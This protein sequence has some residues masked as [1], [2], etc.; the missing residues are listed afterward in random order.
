MD[1]Q[2]RIRAASARKPALYLPGPQTPIE[3]TGSSQRSVIQY[4]RQLWRAKGLILL[5]GAA[6]AILALTVSLLEE[7][8]YRST[9]SLEIEDLNENLFNTGDVFPAAR[10]SSTDSYLQTQIEVL[11]SRSLLTRVAKAMKLDERYGKPGRPGKLAQLRIW[12]GLQPQRESTPMERAVAALS[13]GLEIVEPRNGSRIVRIEYSSGDPQFAADVAN[14]IAH[15]FIEQSMDLRL[16]STQHTGEWLTRQVEEMRQKLQQSE[17]AMQA[18]GQSAGLL[19]VNDDKDN[20]ADARLRQ[21]QEELSR[22]QAERMARQS[23]YELVI[24]T[25]QESLADVLDNGP[26]QQYQ[27]KLTDAR[28]QLAQLSALLTPSH[29][30]VKQAEAQVNELEA[31][32]N[33]ER[34]RF[35]DR[36][37]SDYQSAL[38]H[39]QLLSGAYASQARL[40]STQDAK[41]SRYNILKREVETNRQ[42]YDAML[43]KVKGIHLVSAMRTSNIA[44][45]DPAQPPALPF[46][47]KPILNASAGLLSGLFLGAIFGLFRDRWTDKLKDPDEVVTILGIPGLGIIPP[48]EKLPRLKGSGLALESAPAGSQME[49]ASLYSPRSTVADSFRATLASILFATSTSGKT[50][51]RVISLTSAAPREGKTAAV[52]NLGVALARIGQRVLLIDGDMRKPRLHTIFGLSNENGLSEILA[53]T[54]VITDITEFA[55]PTPRAGLSV[56]TSGGATAESTDLLHSERLSEVIN[57]ARKKYD[58]V[59]IDSPPLLQLVDARLLSWHTDGVVLVCRSGSTDRQA[60]QAAVRL[61]QSDGT[62]VLGVILND[63]APSAQASYYYSPSGYYPVNQA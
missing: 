57:L 35:V 9:A 58:T 30:K 37:T 5:C 55:K 38:R 33:A 32:L 10:G 4:I 46:Q 36:I 11:S 39:E 6:C 43:Q 48:A 3:E 29:Y 12:L 16:K 8:M 18:Y 44:V 22:A 14:T 24:K 26:L 34:K 2:Y 25:P 59:I 56:I 27:A 53:E 15:E 28:Q 61:L 41:A 60:A 47:P 19:F 42:L 45:F 1:H 7:P 13:D 51:V 50:R 17:D 40:V 52:T 31:A 21:L 20:V 63:C 23:R 49:L 62:P 54:E